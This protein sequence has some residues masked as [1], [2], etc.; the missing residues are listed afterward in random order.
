MTAVYRT[1]LLKRNQCP[2]VMSGVIYIRLLVVIFIYYENGRVLISVWV[3][4][5]CHDREQK[6]HY[7][8]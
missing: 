7:I 6:C 3:H 4:K 1:N 8:I 2:N 5:L